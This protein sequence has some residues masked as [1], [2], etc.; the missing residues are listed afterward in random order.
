MIRSLTLVVG[1][2]GTLDADLFEVALG[3]L[4]EQSSRALGAWLLVLHR[5]LAYGLVRERQG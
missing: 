3:E 1:H 4:G 2:G 5:I